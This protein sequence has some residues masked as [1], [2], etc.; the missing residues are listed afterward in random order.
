MKRGM[1]LGR[2]RHTC[3]GRGLWKIDLSVGLRDRA[4]RILGN[5]TYDRVR[6]LILGR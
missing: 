1:D 6:A 5:Q 3:V 4:K 2:F